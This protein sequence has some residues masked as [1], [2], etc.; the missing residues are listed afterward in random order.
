MVWVC[1]KLSCG[2]PGCLSTAVGKTFNADTYFYNLSSQPS[3][4]SGRL[5]QAG[6]V[7]WHCLCL[8]EASM[9]LSALPVQLALYWTLMYWAMWCACVACRHTHCWVEYSICLPSVRFSNSKPALF[10]SALETHFLWTHPVWFQVFSKLW[11]T[12]TVYPV[13]LIGAK[14]SHFSL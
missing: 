6:W 14:F 13:L 8:C 7:P 1:D 2:Q 9:C 12:R 10:A 11:L 4:C 5:G 3:P